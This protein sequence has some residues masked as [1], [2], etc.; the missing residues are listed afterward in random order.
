MKGMVVR[1]LSFHQRHAQKRPSAREH[2]LALRIIPSALSPSRRHHIIQTSLLFSTPHSHSLPPHP[3]SRLL[4]HHLLISLLF[5]AVAA[6]SL[7]IRLQCRKH[8]QTRSL[9]NHFC[10]KVSWL[11]DLFSTIN[12][13]TTQHKHHATFCTGNRKS[14]ALYTPN[15]FSP[16]PRNEI[17]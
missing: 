16:L 17:L 14:I 7:P 6:S 3:S 13:K 2:P 12:N 10:Q 4:S 5:E 9:R 1:E 15:H 8:P 11:L